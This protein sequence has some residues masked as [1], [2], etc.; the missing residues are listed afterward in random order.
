MIF[1]TQ[2]KAL[3]LMRGNRAAADFIETAVKVLHFWD[4]L[5]DRDKPLDDAAINRA[6]LDALV[7][8]PRNPFYR[9][10]FET[11]SSVLM[12]SITNWHVATKFERT[13]DEYRRHIAYILRSSYVD[14][15]TTSALL[16]GGPDYAVQ[17]GEQIRLYAHQETWTGYLANLATE[18]TAREAKENE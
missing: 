3:E 14:L 15:I 16:V 8:L 5:I 2:G 1:D 17:V 9:A 7:V 4:D 6:M 18:T 10:N 12:N 13:G 11:L